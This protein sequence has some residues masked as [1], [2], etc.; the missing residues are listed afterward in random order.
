MRTRATGIKTGGETRRVEG[1]V[2]ENK[3]KTH[4]ENDTQ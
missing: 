3:G 4:R 2:N 1:W